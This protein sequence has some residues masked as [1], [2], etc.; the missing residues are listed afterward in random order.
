ME[1]A[2]PG[3]ALPAPPE[4]A[5]ATTLGVLA[6]VLSFVCFPVGIVLGILALLKCQEARRAAQAQPD[7]FRPAKGTGQVLGI[8][9]IAVGPVLA[10]L[11]I[12]SAIAIP[13]LLSQRARARDKAAI[14][15]MEGA[16]PN[17]VD[18]AQRDPRDLPAA[19]AAWVRAQPDRNPWNPQ[20]PVFAYEVKVV[21]GADSAET[22]RAWVKP[23]AL[24]T[25]E[26]VLAVQVPGPGTPGFVAGAVR[27]NGHVRGEPVLTS[28]V[29]LD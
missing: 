11:G 29:T 27:I 24:T 12:I 1:Y 16:L 6:L 15:A 18:L 10:F 22:M 25:G 13:A 19:A 23:F 8:L 26:V 7:R 5:T 28:V 14:Q 3:A 17:L 21:Q 20:A 2:G 4:E 9:A